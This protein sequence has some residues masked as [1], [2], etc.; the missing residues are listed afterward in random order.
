MSRPIRK[1]ELKKLQKGEP[2]AHPAM[3][4]DRAMSEI[5]GLGEKMGLPE[6]ETLRKI[7]RYQPFASGADLMVEVK[8]QDEKIDIWYWTEKDQNNDNK[9][10]WRKPAGDSP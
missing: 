4:R 3:S 5:L 1:G 6:S 10:W 9:G 2:Q 7:V 8:R